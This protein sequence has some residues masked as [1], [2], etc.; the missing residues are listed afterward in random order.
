MKK[1]SALF[2]FFLVV[3]ATH[4][5]AGTFYYVA[6]SNGNDNNP[7]TQDLPWKTIQKAANGMIAGDTVFV[8][9]G[10]YNERVSI[11]K[12]GNSGNPISFRINPGNSV[13]VNGGFTIT[14]NYVNIDGFRVTGAWTC[15][16]GQNDYNIYVDSDFVE[17]ANIYCYGGRHAGIM[18]FLHSDYCIIRDSEFN[19]CEFVAMDVRGN[20]HIIE[21][22]DIHDSRCSDCA[23]D[24]GGLLFCGSG[25]V[26]KRN[27]IHDITFA[28]SPG[29]NPH[30]DGM[31]CNYDSN[32]PL[33]TDCLFEQNLIDLPDYK[34]TTQAEVCG[35]FQFNAGLRLTVKNNIVRAFRGTNT[36]AYGVT[37]IK[38]INNTFIGSMSYPS[39]L[40]PEGINVKKS[41]NPYIRNNIIVDQPTYPISV[42]GATGVDTDY[43]LIFNS[44]GVPPNHQDTRRAHDL[45]MMDPRF[46]DPGK[47][48][49]HL[50]SDSPAIDMGMAASGVKDD[51]DGNIRP[52]GP[53]YDV[54]SFEYQGSNPQSPV[55]SFAASP[56]QGQAPLFVNFDASASHDPDGTI[57]S[58]A[59]NFG[60]GTTGTGIITS[61]T[62]QFAGTLTAKLTVTDNDNH[63]ASA[64]CNIQIAGDPVPPVAS[65]VAT[66][67]TSQLPIIVQ[68]DASSSTDPAGQIAKYTWNFGDGALGTGKI[69]NHAYNQESTYTVTLT[70]EG[71]E[72]LTN[73][74]SKNVTIAATPTAK[75]IGPGWTRLGE[76]VTYDASD[77]TPSATGGQII[78]YAWNFGDGA[79]AD[80]KIVSHAYQSVGN[81]SVALRVIDNR[82]KTNSATQSVKVYSMTKAA[83]SYAPTTG[84][85]AGASVAF[86]AS[87]SSGAIVSYKWDFDDGT[88][89]T[90]RNITHSFSKGGRYYRVTLTVTN[91]DG[92]KATSWK[93]VAVRKNDS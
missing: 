41:T 63:T 12:S 45:W 54:G 17:I 19:Q 1:I 69:V 73:Q 58:Y 46:V 13:T 38:I 42:D 40:G 4:I 78:S 33:A 20:N 9:G 8:M 84:I 87:A 35:G 92:Y 72:G 60:D 79:T 74:A 30:I 53:G 91:V 11:T 62:Y 90:G 44:N 15:N 75:I 7:G 66:P 23:Y 28:N 68:F 77:S 61:H 86:D 64:T 2:I 36:G 71:R 83:F 80:G 55:P 26:F 21:N 70:V 29:H 88:T 67:T 59:W 93:S 50:Q 81:F 65:F 34:G 39:S 22:N 14:G 27:Y 52:Q 51:Y 82:N 25:H 32:H 47:H 18:L 24:A 10:T 48:N 5:F 85:L 76:T 31:E 57:T 89:G 6:A 49:Y 43:N 3:A 56:N 37:D 16:W